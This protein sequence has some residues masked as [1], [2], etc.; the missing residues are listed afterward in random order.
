MINIVSFFTS[1]Y[2]GFAVFSIIGFMANEAGIEVDK[3]IDSGKLT[4]RMSSHPEVNVITCLGYICDH[5]WMRVFFAG[6]GLA[7]IVYPR[8]LSMMPLA[9]MWSA[10]FFFMLF[11]LGIGSQ[12]SRSYSTFH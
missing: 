12:V 4:M 8:A 1:L 7:F 9:P 3:V 2:A 5:F 10:L 6:P 11:L